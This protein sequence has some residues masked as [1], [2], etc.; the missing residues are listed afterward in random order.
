M[1]EEVIGGHDQGVWTVLFHAEG[2]TLRGTPFT[3]EGVHTASLWK[4]GDSEDPRESEEPTPKRRLER[5][6]L[7]V[8]LRDAEL[9]KLGRRRLTAVGFSVDELLRD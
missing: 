4:G 7:L 6:A 5:E 3:R 8:L 2:K 9:G 1:F